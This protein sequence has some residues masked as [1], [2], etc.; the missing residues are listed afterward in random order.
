MKGQIEK[1][2]TLPADQYDEIL[3]GIATELIGE[4]KCEQA[5]VVCMNL[6]E[7]QPV[8]IILISRLA[9]QGNVALAEALAITLGHD[10]SLSK[11]SAL[12]VDFPLFVDWGQHEAAK[13]VALRIHSPWDRDH[14]LEKI[15][16]SAIRDGMPLSGIRSASAISG[17]TIRTKLLHNVAMNL[18]DYRRGMEEEVVDKM[19]KAGAPPQELL[20][21]GEHCLTPNIIRRVV[22][23]NLVPDSVIREQVKSL[24]VHRQN[25]LANMIHTEFARTLAIREESH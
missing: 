15:Y 2:L 16:S 14:A 9:K 18:L 20:D 13:R 5:G 7:E 23:E 19:L 24:R 3:A 12:F 25:A 4:E 22:Y 8:I 6:L 17:K 1:A 11:S 21:W 10:D